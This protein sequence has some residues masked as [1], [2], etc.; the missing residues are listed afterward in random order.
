MPAKGRPSPSAGAKRPLQAPG[1]ASSGA[2]LRAGGGPRRRDEAADGGAPIDPASQAALGDFLEAVRVEDGLSRASVAAYRADLLLFLTW[3]APRPLHGLEP[4]Q[5]VGWL[6][7]LRSAGARETTVAR[8]FSAL[9]RFV[10][11]LVAEGRIARDSTALFDAPRLPKPLPKALSQEEIARL[12]ACEHEEPG[13]ARH[14]R[15]RAL[16]ETL[17]AC[18]GRVSEVVGLALDDFEPALRVVRLFG[19]GSKARVVPLGARARAALEA[20][21]AGPRRELPGHG[22]EQRVFLST[23]GKPLSRTAAWRIVQQAALAAGLRGAVSP[24]ALR[25]SFATHLVEGGAD[26]RSV[27]EMLGHSSIR[28]TEVYTRLDGDA[29]LALHRLHHPRG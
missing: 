6:G 10:R 23:R 24:H 28:T 3:F 8:K 19:K 16:L 5:V 9:R 2:P 27:Q 15:D 20:W 25:H 4:E 11:F 1:A 17:Y 21:I 12:L 18:G 14:V 22:R 13:S 7:A 29:L 26:L